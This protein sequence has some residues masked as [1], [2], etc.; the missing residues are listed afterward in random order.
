M[1]VKEAVGVTVLTLMY[2]SIE[3]RSIAAARQPV[4]LI[5][6]TDDNGEQIFENH[7]MLDSFC[8]DQS[9]HSVIPGISCT[10]EGPL[11]EIGRCATYEKDVGFF[12]SRCPYYRLKGHTVSVSKPG[13]IVL[14]ENVSDLNDYMCGPMNRKG[15]LCKDCIEGFGPSV[16]SMGYQCSNCTDIWYGIPLLILVEYAPATLFYLI[17]LVFKV[18]LTSAPM[19]L[20]IFYS[21]L[22]MYFILSGLSLKQP[23]QKMFAQ[24]ENDP[25][26]SKVVLLF[27]GLWNLDFVRYIVPPFCVSRILRPSH[28]E[29]LDF[30]SIFYLLFLVFLTW[31]LIE[32][33]GRNFR[34]LVWLWKPFHKCF[35]K[36]Q[37]KWDT[38]NDI[39]DVFASLF[40]LFYVKI[41][42]LG[43]VLYTCYPITYTINGLKHNKCVDIDGHLPRGMLS[44]FAIPFVI[45]FNIL[46]TL[47]LILYPF[48]LFR[49]CLSKCR[50]DKLFVTIFVEKFHGCYRDGLNGGRDMRSFSGMYLLMILLLANV[51]FLNFKE[52]KISHW[53]FTTFIVLIFVLLTAFLR[54]YKKTYMTILDTLLLTHFAVVCLLLS[55][56]Y[57]SGEETQIFIILL[58]PAGAFGFF[59]IFKLVLNLKNLVLS[60]CKQCW[61]R[62]SIHSKTVRIQD[63]RQLINTTCTVVDIKSYGTCNN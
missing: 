17:I 44:F 40:L 42:Y 16:T 22:M 34:P 57:F 35:V 10:E 20:Y 45:I 9:P 12:S 43:S 5:T 25:I 31:L 61:R 52:L 13:F 32:L 37:R 23:L 60:H 62:I 50:L 49:K 38:R 1:L 6:A 15:F 11:L 58:L 29:W 55:R 28:I 14:P 36:F 63:Q 3:C 47:L 18:H 56:N 33:H 51:G 54:P 19:I 27:F 46:P 8:Q 41:L 53:L 24:S 2:L 39:I 30:L 21:Q 26:L 59:I 4:S 7:T 48:K